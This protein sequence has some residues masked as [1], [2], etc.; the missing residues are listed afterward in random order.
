MPEF[1]GTSDTSNFQEALDK[2]VQDALRAIQ[3]TEPMVSYVVKRIRGTKGGIGGFTRVTVVI[4]TDHLAAGRETKSLVVE[5]CEACEKLHH[6]LIAYT[7]LFATMQW[8][9]QHT[10]RIVEYQCPEKGKIARSLATFGG[11]VE[12]VEII[13]VENG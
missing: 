11:P 13:R 3:H 7:P 9:P 10:S 1:E 2:A 12:D 4:E 6:L 5:S 8:P